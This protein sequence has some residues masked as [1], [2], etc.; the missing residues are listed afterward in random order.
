MENKYTEKGGL[1]FVLNR[2]INI[3]WSVLDDTINK[4]VEPFTS[5]YL[6]AF[7]VVN[8]VVLVGSSSHIP[9]PHRHD[10]HHAGTPNLQSPDLANQSP[11]SLTLDFESYHNS[12]QVIALL[13]IPLLYATIARGGIPLTEISSSHPSWSL[14]T[15]ERGSLLWT[16]ISCQSPPITAIQSAQLSTTSKNFHN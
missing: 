10:K 16:K 4:I 6:F 12:Y 1:G 14:S 7:G 9:L 3:G 8:W 2:K 15:G 11:P 5:H 13:V